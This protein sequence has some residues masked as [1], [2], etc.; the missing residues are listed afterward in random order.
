MIMHRHIPDIA[1]IGAGPAGLACAERL[2]E[3]GLQVQIYDA[4]KAP[5]GRL[6]GQRRFGLSFE[7]GAPGRQA[8]VD[9]L[10]A[11][12]PVLQKARIASLQRTAGVWRLQV[13]D[14]PFCGLHSTVVLA[15]PAPE[16]VRLW[17]ALRP[18]LASV[19][20][21]PVLSALL[22]LPG[23]LRRAWHRVTFPEGSLAEA[24]RQQPGP[25]GAPEAWVLQASAVFSRD[26]LECGLDGIAR[27]LWLRF[28]DALDLDGMSPS[29][30]LGHRWR[31]G[32]TVAPWGRS[33]WFDERLALGVCGDWCL[34]DNVEA[35]VTSGRALADRMLG[36]VERPPRIT[37]DVQE[38]R[39]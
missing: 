6:A 34:G 28:R 20:I 1:V 25:P 2:A 24:R 36:T 19:R 13:A 21:A 37:L 29:F 33:C 7:P 18:L 3:H 14:A 39:A 11:R 16:A 8:L 35:A 15:V 10:A 12:V 4:G 5:G 23:P 27:H 9:S 26:N 38:G 30:L 22:G 31:H 17:P 32:L